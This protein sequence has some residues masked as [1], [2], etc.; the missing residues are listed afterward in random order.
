MY[1][2]I[3]VFKMNESI[4]FIFN[5]HDTSKQRRSIF[6]INSFCCIIMKINIDVINKF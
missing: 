3:K 6:Y 4:H 1:F 2:T 5:I